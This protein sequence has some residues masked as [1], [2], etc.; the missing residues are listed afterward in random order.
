MEVLA[1]DA[2]EVEFVAA[3]GRAQ[4]LLTLRASG[5]RQVGDHDLIAGRSLERADG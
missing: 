3:S 1:S 2:L 4:A 5:I